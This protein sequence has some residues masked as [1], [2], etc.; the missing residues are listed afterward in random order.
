MQKAKTLKNQWKRGNLQTLQIYCASIHVHASDRN[1]FMS[2]SLAVTHLGIQYC[3]HPVKPPRPPQSPK[4]SNGRSWTTGHELQ[5][6]SAIHSQLWLVCVSTSL[7]YR[8][9]RIIQSE[10]S[11]YI[12]DFFSKINANPMSQVS[13]IVGLDRIV[14]TCIVE[15]VSGCRNTLYISCLCRLTWRL[16]F[17]RILPP[18]WQV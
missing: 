9:G 3:A 6:F 12:P 11:D 8:H 17:I 1:T 18:Q 14:S 15:S 7:R 10:A 4:L 5:L 2:F 13:W 16:N